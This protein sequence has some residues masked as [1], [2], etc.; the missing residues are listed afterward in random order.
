MQKLRKHCFVSIVL[1]FFNIFLK[2]YNEK[3]IILVVFML[4]IFL[5]GLLIKN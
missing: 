2:I 4:K 1:I 5:R 3:M